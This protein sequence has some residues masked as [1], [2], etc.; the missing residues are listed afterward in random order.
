MGC[1]ECCISYEFLSFYK[2]IV[3]IGQG[4]LLILQVRLE[5]APVKALLCT[6]PTP[7]QSLASDSYHPQNCQVIHKHHITWLPNKAEQQMVIIYIQISDQYLGPTPILIHALIH[8]LGS[9][10]ASSNSQAG[11]KEQQ[12]KCH[13]AEQV[14]VSQEMMREIPHPGEIELTFCMQAFLLLSISSGRPR[15][16]QIVR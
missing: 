8:S 13:P 5:L 12:K 10:V 1:I 16:F 2:Y 15:V 7:I 3:N 11:P 6:W 14:C 4:N 9:G